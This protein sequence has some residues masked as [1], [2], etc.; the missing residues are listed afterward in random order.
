MTHHTL[1]QPPIRIAALLSLTILAVACGEAGAERAE[2][3]AVRDSAGVR[4]I[5]SSDAVWAAEEGWRV[6]SE[7][8]L[9]IGLTE[10]PAEYLLDQVSGARRLANGRIVVANAGSGEL[11]FY[12]P[13]GAHLFSAG[14][15][16]DGPGEFRRIA[17]LDDYRGDSLMVYDG[18]ARRASV[19]SGDG[20]YGRS[21]TFPSVGEG[22]TPTA[23]AAF[24]DGTIVG[25][26]TVVV[27]PEQVATGMRK[28]DAM[29]GRFTA[30]DGTLIDSLAS[31][32]ARERHLLM[33]PQMIMITDPL[34]AP[35]AYLA[36][37]GD[38]A[39]L[40]FSQSPEVGVY[41]ADGVLRRLIRW[42]EEPV[43][44]SPEELERLKQARLGVSDDEG[45]QQRMG[46]VLGMMPAPEVRPAYDG[47]IADDVGNLW[48]Q[49]AIVPGEPNLWTVFDP[50]G[51]MLGPVQFPDEFRPLHIGEDFVLG[52]V[53]DELDVE[54]A[55]MYGLE[56]G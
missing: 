42:R 36:V 43:P 46:R 52:V 20:A 32:P 56:K 45:Y 12:A 13:D 23:A 15:E 34:L 37:S 22:G 44:V 33:E 1:R 24:A 40:G 3:V 2:T 53:R 38:S 51:R 10:G 21:L 55:R 14:G 18:A 48:V 39:F 54:R 29:Y 30:E 49:E 35:D 26:L 7:P 28:S 27:Q 6:S 47:L 5:E 50:E 17:W 4:I 31:V 8:L 11:R 16:G 25:R 19:I 9:E 41:G